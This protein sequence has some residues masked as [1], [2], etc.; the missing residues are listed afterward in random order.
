[1]NNLPCAVHVWDPG[2]LLPNQARTRVKRRLS[3][4]I[5]LGSRASPSKVHQLL[6]RLDHQNWAIETNCKGFSNSAVRC[7]FC[8]LTGGQLL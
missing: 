2:V 3:A 8:G 1:M 4:G 7:I 6:R 5:D